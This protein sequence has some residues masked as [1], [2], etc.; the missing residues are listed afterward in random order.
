[1]IQYS[2]FVDREDV[3]TVEEEERNGFIK[4]TLKQI[5]L[6]IDDIWPEIL[7]SLEEKIKLRDYLNKFDILILDT[8]DTFEIYV[9]KELV[10]KW[11]RPL[12]ALKTDLSEI[13]PSKKIFVEMTIM[14]E[15]IFENDVDSNDEV[16][17]G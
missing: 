2:I 5:G 14:H 13:N 1:M 3:K 17:K 12:F 16:E 4:D 11:Y 15:S 7:L 8:K 10:A 6:D 9:G